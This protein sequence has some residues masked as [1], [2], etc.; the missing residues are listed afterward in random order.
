MLDAIHAATHENLQL[1]E[2]VLLRGVDVD[3][4]L[5]ADDPAAALADAITEAMQN[6]ACRIGATKAGCVFRC[7]PRM[8]DMTGGQRTPAAGELLAVRWEATLSGTLLEITPANAAMLLSIPLFISS[9]P[10][11]L[12]Q[13]EAEPIPDAAGDLCWVGDMGGGL[14][15]IA[16]HSP[17]STGGMVFRASR[18]G[19]GEADFTL[20]AQMRSPRDQALPCRLIWLK[21]VPA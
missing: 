14:L 15:A 21:E 7:V 19:L 12:L 20:M 1:G 10:C 8:A 13:P 18:S 17:A 9:R 2:G 5:A 3:A 11:T 6:A 16:L 4:A